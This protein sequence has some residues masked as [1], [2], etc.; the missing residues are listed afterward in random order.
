MNCISYKFIFFTNQI[1]S[2][3]IN[4]QQSILTDA[5]YQRSKTLMS[6]YITYYSHSHLILRK[7]A[8]SFALL[9]FPAGSV[10]RWTWR[11]LNL[12]KEGSD[13]KKERAGRKSSVSH[14]SQL[15][16]A[17]YHRSIRS[18]REGA[19]SCEIYVGRAGAIFRL[20]HFYGFS[21]REI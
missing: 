8:C 12:V 6:V 16:P 1:I 3:I 15:P 14:R 7:R 10:P 21:R 20:L 5:A 17:I 9:L 19:R 18:L 4:E 11:N 13:L 2:L